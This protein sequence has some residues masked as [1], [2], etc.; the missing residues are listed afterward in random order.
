[1]QIGD[2]LTTNNGLP[3]GAAPTAGMNRFIATPGNTQGR[4]TGT[5]P[6]TPN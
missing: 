1:M 4:W 5:V 2:V 6:V 3:A